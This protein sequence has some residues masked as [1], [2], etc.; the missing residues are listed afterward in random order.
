MAASVTTRSIDVSRSGANTAEAVLTP[1]AVKTRGMKQALVLRTPDDPRLEAQPLYLPGT[2]VGSKAHNVVFQATMGNWIYAWDADTGEELWK[3]CLGRPIN[4]S[5]AIDAHLINVHWGILS[6]PVIDPAAGRLYACYWSSQDGSWQHGQ[7][8]LASL[9]IATGAQTHPG[10]NLEGAEFDP[11]DGLRTLRFRSMERK[12]RAAL[13]MVGNAVLIPFG[14]IAESGGDARGW[15]IAVDVKSWA[16]SA[17]WCSTA[18]GAGAGIW[19]SGSGPAV[20]SNGSI[21]LVTGNGDFDGVHDFGESAVRLRYTAPADG[22]KGALTVT[23]WWTPW[24]DDGR[25]GEN[26]GAEAIAAALPKRVPS[27][28]RIGPHLARLGMAHLGGT[29]SD[30]DLG[31]SGIVLVEEVGIAL[32]SGKDGVLYTI[33]L[34]HPGNTT[35]AELAPAHVAANFA[36]LAAPPI[37]YT[38]YDPLVNPAPTDPIALNRFAANR[39]HH[40]HGTPIAWKSAT[41]SWMHYCGGENGNLRAWRLQPHGTSEY[42]AC[43][44]VYASPESAVPYGGMPGWS[45]ALS[46]NGG[47]GAIIWAMVPYDDANM[48]ITNT[49]LLAYDAETFGHFGDGSGEIMPLWDS[50]QWNWNILHPKFN[51]PVAVDG[52]VLVP[53]YGGEL[54]V[55]TLA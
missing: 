47:E 24:T 10:L 23:G 44:E 21:W 1:T 3:T 31:A 14:T 37:L 46:A 28:F 20:Q 55:L 16:V 32:V 35:Q 38:Y 6:T 36:K 2:R 7:H 48:K 50:Q 54:L 52:K 40:L 49:R 17:V 30:Q 39:T 18:R 26:P 12:Q 51:R 13:T 15:L 41:R 42:L 53:T 43:S 8:F 4:G 29:W 11:G 27:N 19:M 9:D 34:D 5:D 25:E 45:I 33:R 22:A